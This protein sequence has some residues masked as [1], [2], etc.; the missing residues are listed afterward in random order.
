MT[1]PIAHRSCFG[2]TRAVAVVCGAA[3]ALSAFGLGSTAAFATSKPTAIVATATVP[4]VGTVL[5]DAR[6]RTLYTLTNA[7]RAVPCTGPC[8]SAW[9]PL[10]VSAG[11]KLKGAKGTKSLAMMAATRQVTSGGLPLYRFAGDTKTHQANGNNLT[12]FGGTW[13][14]VKVSGTT[15]K[16]KKPSSTAGSGYGY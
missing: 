14:V 13:H 4:G 12:S 6:G 8:A 2:V 3:L 16:A 5:V 15:T 11:A 10:V 7:G 9:P 1:D